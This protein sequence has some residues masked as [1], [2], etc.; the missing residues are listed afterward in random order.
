MIPY[1][2]M[3]SGK[4]SHMLAALAASLLLHLIAFTV[5]SRVNLKPQ[6]SEIKEYIPADLVQLPSTSRDTGPAPVAVRHAVVPQH[7]EAP[8]P[9]EN[10]ER[11]E[12]AHLRLCNRLPRSQNHI[13]RR[14]QQARH[15]TLALLLC[16]GAGQKDGLREAQRLRPV[17]KP[18]LRNRRNG[19]RGA[20]RHFNG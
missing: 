6:L 5:V 3:I 13:Q 2:D 11:H 12:P 20:T 7:P 9:V 14:Q 10:R 15:S 8:A 4:N 16:P 19:T 17:S 18:A 1:D